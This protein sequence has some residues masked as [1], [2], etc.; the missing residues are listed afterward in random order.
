MRYSKSKILA[1]FL[2]LCLCASVKQSK[3]QSGR[4][5]F[6]TRIYEKNFYKETRIFIDSAFAQKTLLA[7]LLRQRIPNYVRTD[8]NLC[9]QQINQWFE[10]YA[11]SV[12]QC[13]YERVKKSKIPSTRW[14]HK[15]SVFYYYRV[16]DTGKVFVNSAITQ[17]IVMCLPIKENLFILLESE[18]VPKR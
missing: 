7:M 6:A 10:N 12:F 1:A 4:H 17:S 9:K 8:T 3:A 13:L 15:E 18:L 2:F 14:I 5:D 11:D 16:L